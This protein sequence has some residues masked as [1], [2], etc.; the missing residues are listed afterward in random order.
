M[1]IKVLFEKSYLAILEAEIS[2]VEVDSIFVF[3]IHRRNLRIL[4]A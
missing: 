3:Y 1:K 4:V 2:M